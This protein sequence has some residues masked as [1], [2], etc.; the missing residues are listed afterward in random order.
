MSHSPTA[1]REKVV[2]V[3]AVN[4]RSRFS[5]AKIKSQRKSQSPDWEKPPQ[6]S[7]IYGIQAGELDHLDSNPSS[8]PYSF[9]SVLPICVCQ[10]L[11]P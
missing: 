10:F 11:L 1:L 7:S 3:K 9:L 8:V 4:N 2:T 6:L 5:V